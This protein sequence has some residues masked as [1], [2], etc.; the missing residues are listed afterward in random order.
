[1]KKIILFLIATAGALNV[2]EQN[3]N[4][5]SDFVGHHNDYVK[6][7]HHK[8]KKHKEKKHRD[9]AP[10]RQEAPRQREHA[11]RPVRMKTPIRQDTMATGWC[12][13]LNAI[14]GIFTQNVTS[15]SLT[16]AYSN[17]ANSKVS[18]P[19]FNNGCEFGFDAEVGYFFGLKR[20]FGIGTGLM[21]I[22]EHSTA[23]IDAFHMES[24][25]TDVFGNTYRQEITANGQIKETWKTS[26]FNI[27][28]LL[29]YKTKFSNK[30]GF[31][32]DAGI[33]INLSETTNYKTNAS[34]DYEAVYQY[35]LGENGVTTT[36]DNGAVPASSDLLITKSQ[37]LSTHSGANIQD[38]FNSLKNQGYNVGLGVKPASTKG[39][40]SY[41]SGSVGLLLRPAISIYLADNFTLNLGVYYLYQN[42]SRDAS[43]NYKIT[44][45]TGSYSPVLNSVSSA[46]NNSY[47]LTAGLRYCFSR[48][49]VGETMPPPAPEDDLVVV[50]EDKAPP[51]SSESTQIPVTPEA[52]PASPVE[53]PEPDNHVDISTP[54]LFDINKTV[55]KRSSYPILQEAIN[56]LKENPDAY[57]VIH[58]YTDN[59]GTVAYNKVLS[60][61]RAQA[62][63]NYLR[64]HGVRTRTL[65]TV[66][67]GESSP[68]ASNHTRAG[69][70]KNR[71]AVMKLKAE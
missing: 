59:T 43:A 55:I 26:N 57:L 20:H 4:P 70:A 41:T 8:E 40:A 34:F 32:A 21:Y 37:Y 11:T 25:A 18:T 13:E 65:K 7:R 6:E 22:Y 63:K 48:G 56:Q 69:R 49:C 12:V 27:P 51:V 35:V 47:G 2:L 64:K 42:F 54:L 38:Y 10:R 66:G 14:G 33:L 61:K 36:Y 9:E 71:R 39:S 23:T 19:Q 24:R 52:P 68:A 60:R 53:E 62:V 45:K 58:G 50:E 16:S 30:I 46:S 15:G 44:D 1:M 5:E 31:T 17:I 3:I 29:K 67:H 28:L